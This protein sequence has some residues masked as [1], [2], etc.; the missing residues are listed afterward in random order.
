MERPKI[1]TLML[2][3]MPH[4]SCL[5]PHAAGAGAGAGAIAAPAASCH[6]LQRLTIF[7]RRAMVSVPC[8]FYVQLPAI[9]TY[10]IKLYK[11]TEWQR[12]GAMRCDGQVGSHSPCTVTFSFEFKVIEKIFDIKC[13]FKTDLR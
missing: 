4:A 8:V 6:K 3:L 2:M 10:I 9:Y 12:C 5:M 11:P 13:D 7:G 1:L